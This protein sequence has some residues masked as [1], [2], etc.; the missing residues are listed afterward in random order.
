MTLD[1]STYKAWIGQKE[2]SSDFLTLAPLRGLAATLNKV[3]LDYQPGDVL[4]PL[5]HWLYFLSPARQS[6]LGNDGHAERGDFLPPI[7]LPR[8]MWAGSRFE[9]HRP[10][11]AGEKISRVSTIKSIN[12][13]AGRSGQLAFVT[14]KHEISTELEKAISEEHDIVYRDHVPADAAPAEPK[15]VEQ[16]ADYF[17]SINPDPVLLFRYSALTFN[18]HRIHYDRDYVTKVE[19]YPG[20]IVHGPLLATLLVDLLAEQFP[21]KS[22]Q[23]FE[24]RAMNPVFDL[25]PFDVCGSNPDQNGNL[26]L[27]IKDHNNALCMQ[28][29]ANIV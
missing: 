2:S 19:G 3:Q 8:R 22:L 4:P 17:K 5:W 15:Q 29:R 10:L 14:V 9:F 11:H 1:A 7:P 21:E 18:G 23:R 16:E 13:K 12:F 28:A 27:W 6:K 24:F 25:N 26:N 20:L